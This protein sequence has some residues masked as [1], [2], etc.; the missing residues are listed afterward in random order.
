MGQKANPI[1]LRL[2]INRTW[3]SR[4]FAVGETYSRQLLQDIALRELVEKTLKNASVSKVIIERVAKKVSVVIFSSQ[5]GLIIGKKGAD[6]DAL[7]KKLS[8]IAGADVNVNIVEVRRA[9]MDAVITAK[10]VAQQIE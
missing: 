5:P 6:I 2:D 10:S 9:D 1:G 3:D 4:W 7:K 8:K